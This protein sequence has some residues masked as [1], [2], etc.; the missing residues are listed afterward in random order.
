MRVDNKEWKWK[1]KVSRI[2]VGQ[3]SAVMSVDKVQLPAVWNQVVHLR[4]I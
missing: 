3:A 1:Y 2:I 4:L